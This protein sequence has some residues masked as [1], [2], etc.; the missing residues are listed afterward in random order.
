MPNLFRGEKVLGNMKYLMG[1][2]KQ[3]VEAVGI[4]TEY[5]WDANRVDLL[6]TMVYG[7]FNYK[8]NKIFD[9]L[10]WS[11]VVMDFYTNRCII[12]GIL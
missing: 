5:N 2:V 9:S 10:S 11:S 12:P 6:Y 4:W 7:R 1:S 3:A 8:I